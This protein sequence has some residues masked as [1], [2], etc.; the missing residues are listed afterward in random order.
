GR[1]RIPGLGS[2]SSQ[3]DL[4]FTEVLRDMG[5]RVEIAARTTVVTGPERLRGVDVDMNAFSDTMITLCAIAP[6]AQGPTT[7]KNVAHTRLQETDRLR[8]V[9]TELNRLGIKT[10]TTPSSIRI[11]PGKIR[12]A[13][14]RTYGDHRMAMAFT[15]T[16]LVTPGIGIGDPGCVSKTFPGYFGAL[17]TL[18]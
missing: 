2:S 11:I 9:E 3:G 8:A 15:I 18:R 1:V 16:G 17:E 7:I 14:I 13:V 6:F 10:Q 12:P 5:C 4:R